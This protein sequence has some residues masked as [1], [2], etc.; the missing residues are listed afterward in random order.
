M[1]YSGQPGRRSDGLKILASSAEIARE[2]G[3]PPEHLAELRDEVIAALALADDRPVQTWSG[4]SLPGDR[5]ACSIEADRYVV[6]GPGGVLHLHRLSDR[7]GVRVLGADRPAA[8]L[9]PAFVPGGRFLTV[10]FGLSP[11]EVWDLERG[12]VPAA[13]P[14]DV[15]CMAARGDGRQVAALCPDGELRVYDLPAMTEASRCRLGHRT[16]RDAS[17]TRG[18]PCPGTAA[19]WR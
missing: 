10:A 7:S 11:P 12:E 14:A 5:S 3:A 15:R 13:W 8:R 4:L 18:C 1:R 16:C 2:V 17:R 6:V 9:W 19:T